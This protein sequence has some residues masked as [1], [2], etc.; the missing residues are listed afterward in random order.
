MMRNSFRLWGSGLVAACVVLSSLAIVRPAQAL[1]VFTAEVDKRVR[2]AGQATRSLFR[3]KGADFLALARR[4]QVYLDVKVILDGKKRYQV[5]TRTEGDMR[6]YNVACRFGSWGQLP[7]GYGIEYFIRIGDG[8][9]SRE[10]NIVLYPGSRTD[11]PDNDISCVYDR[12]YPKSAVLRVRGLYKVTTN[13][14]PNRTD[15]QLRPIAR[16][17]LSPEDRKALP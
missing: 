7:M 15:V 8:K 2:T 3:K 17:S 1:K 11:H 9:S 13:E 4:R 6:R 5:M 14:Y 12:R 10:V 16:A